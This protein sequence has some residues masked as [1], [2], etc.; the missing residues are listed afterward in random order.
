MENR[1]H[2]EV[3]LWG[4]VIEH[5][6]GWRAQFA[7]PKSF[8]V[9]A[10]ILPSEM[11]S[12][13]SWLAVLRAYRCDIFLLVENA[14]VPLWLAESGFDSNGIELIVQ[15]CSALDERRRQ[16]RRLR[17]GNRVAVFGHG[18]AIVEHADRDLVGAILGRRHVLTFERQAVAWDERNRRWETTAEAAIHVTANRPFAGMQKTGVSEMR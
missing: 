11:S 15:Q 4:T 7:Y 18:I 9:P 5:E 14:T 17:R 13:E 1:V 10:A 3:S 2:G 16:Q 12:I 8:V 6:D